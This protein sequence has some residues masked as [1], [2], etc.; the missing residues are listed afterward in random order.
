MSKERSNWSAF[1]KYI[2]KI[3][4]L[5]TFYSEKALP[6]LLQQFRHKP[7]TSEQQLRSYLTLN[8]NIPTNLRVAY[9]HLEDMQRSRAIEQTLLERFLFQ[10]T[11]DKLS[12]LSLARYVE[13]VMP[14]FLYNSQP[15]IGFTPTLPEDE[16]RDAFPF[17][18]DSLIQKGLLTE[19]DI[20]TPEILE[21]VL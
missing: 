13:R 16:L 5:D 15:S 21:E 2:L 3:P 20:F 11:A 14:D 4:G 17:I 7:L 1:E 19:R 6:A 9:P 8:T 18:R 10:I 12:N